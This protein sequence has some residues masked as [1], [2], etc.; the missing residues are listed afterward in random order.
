MGDTVVR[1]ARFALA[2]LLLTTWLPVDAADLVTTPTQYLILKPPKPVV[3]DGKL[4][5][6]DLARSPYT[7]TASGK[8]PLNDV[9]SNDATNPVK[10]DDD[11]SGRAA[12]AWDEQYLYVAGEMIDD[13]LVGVKPAKLA[14]IRVLNA[15]GGVV[16]E[17]PL[18]TDVP[19]GKTLVELREFKAGSIPK[20]GSYTVEVTASVGGEVSAVASAPLRMAEPQ[21]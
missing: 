18:G 13:H 19:P 3:I 10:G 21:P 11:L 17:Q 8:D 1:N 16:I 7:I 2:A 14:A 5:E 15:E 9:H 20:P 12:L 6:W 4:D